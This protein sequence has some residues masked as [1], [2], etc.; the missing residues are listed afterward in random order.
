M[1]GWMG[2]WMDEFANQQL[3]VKTKGSAVTL[4]AKNNKTHMQIESL[5]SSCKTTSVCHVELEC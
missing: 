1:D 5:I 4:Q 2:G 3:T